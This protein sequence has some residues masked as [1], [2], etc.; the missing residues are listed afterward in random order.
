MKHIGKLTVLVVFGPAVF[1]GSQL[2]HAAY[3][4]N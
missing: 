1:V 2:A 4:R 3:M